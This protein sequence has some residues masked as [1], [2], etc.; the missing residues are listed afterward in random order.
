MGILY[1]ERTG[2]GIIGERSEKVTYSVDGKKTVD[3]KTCDNE[4]FKAS[5]KTEDWNDYVIIAKG[6]R[7][8]HKVNG[9]TTCDVYDNDKRKV[10]S[11]ILALQLH[12]GPPMTVQFKEIKMKE[13]K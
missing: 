3:G 8:I 5:I 7:L 12:A 2:R 11:G 10:A 13:L 1:G 9:T 4:K 6:D